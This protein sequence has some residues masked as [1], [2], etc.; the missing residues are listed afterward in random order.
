[1]PLRTKRVANVS[2]QDRALECIRS[3]V[4]VLYRSSRSVETRTGLT[5]AQLAILRQVAR[6]GPLTVND[7]AARVHAG[8]STVSTVLSRLIRAG[9]LRRRQSPDDQRRVLVEITPRGRHAVLRS[10]RPPTE[11][12]LAALSRFSDREAEQLAESLHALLSRMQVS[13]ERA[14]MLFE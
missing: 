11:R 1:M 5:N 7:V 3:L 2:P 6:H 4:R 14:P 10:P 9:Y 13:A 12:L 8:Q